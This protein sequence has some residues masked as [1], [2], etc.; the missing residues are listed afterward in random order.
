MNWLFLFCWKYRYI[1]F[2]EKRQKFFHHFSVNFE[3]FQD[4][5]L[6]KIMLICFLNM[7]QISPRQQN[8]IRSNLDATIL[9]NKAKNLI[10]Y[11]L[12]FIKLQ[13]WIFFK[14]SIRNFKKL[15]KSENINGFGKSEN[16]KLRNVEIKKFRN[17]QKIKN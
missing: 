16:Q 11:H 7:A 5:N 3:H 8:L 17:F 6:F 1:I 10:N 9:K 2:F 13:I 15:S 4:L 14:T 12:L